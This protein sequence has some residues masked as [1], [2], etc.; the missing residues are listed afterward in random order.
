MSGI[1]GVEVAARAST[2]PAGRTLG[3]LSASLSTVLNPRI[4]P[5]A[6]A[7]VTFVVFLPSLWNG[8]VRWDDHLNLLENQNYRGLTW[9]QIRWMFSTTLLGHWIPL[10]W[11]TFGLDYVLWE[12]QPAGYHLT[13][14]VIFALN[15]PVFYFVAL[16]LLR[17][18]AGFTDGTLRLSATAATLFFTIHPLRVE[19]VAW[20]TERRD[21]LSGLFFLLTV[22]MYL[23]ALDATGKRRRWL[24]AGSVGIYVLALV[25]KSSVMVLPLALVVLDIYPLRRLGG[26]WQDWAGAAARRVW[27][28]KIPFMVLGVAGAAVGYYAQSTNMYITPLERYPLSARPAMVFYSLCFYLQKTVVPQGLSPLYEAPIKV[29]LLDRQFFLPALG[30]TVVTVTVVALRKR[31]PAGLAVWAYYAIALGPVIGI[32]HSGHQLTNDRYSYLPGFAF[33]LVFGAVA[34]AVVRGS[35]AGKLR[36][37]FVRALTG[38]GMLW[39]CG[40]AYLS[41]QQVQIWR[42]TETLWRYALDSQP[43]CSVCHGNFGAYLSLRGDLQLALAEFQRVLELR[44]GEPKAVQHLGHTYA[45]LGDFPKAIEILSRYLKQYPNDEDALNNLG[46]ALLISKRPREAL[47]PLQHALRVKPDHIVALVNSGIAHADLGEY[48]EALS[49]FRR[50]IAVKYDTPGAWSGLARIFIEQGEPRAARTAWG[51]LG[52]LDRKQAAAIGPAFLQTW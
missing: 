43:N 24:L 38:L 14:L 31:W 1:E 36:P 16:R 44:P 27:L 40:L 21:V 33:A 49:L 10:T 29:S 18:A 4:I 17:H 39:L 11:L 46:V 15:A 7:L 45:S 19:S 25:S 51:I 8:F 9:A 22:L 28:E 12:M 35:A 6:L 32:V 34:G 48:P 13:S 3:P 23:K 41:V 42:D 2:R 20:A 5:L 52:M 30:V 37:P 26:R 47:E 50:A